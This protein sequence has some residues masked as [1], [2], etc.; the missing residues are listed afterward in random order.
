MTK[1]TANKFAV[2]DREMC[3]AKLMKN[4]TNYAYL[5]C[6]IPFYWFQISIMLLYLFSAQN[7]IQQHDTDDQA[8]SVIERLERLT[9]H[10]SILLVSNQYH[11]A[12]SIF[13]S[14]T[15]TC[16]KSFRRP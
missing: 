9:M 4:S 11:A 2:L 15:D 3:L 8:I 12:I 1:D 16:R 7:Q 5:R 13:S 6:M 10:D 14:K